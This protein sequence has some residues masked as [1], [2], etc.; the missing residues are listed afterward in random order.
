M[1]VMSSTFESISP[2]FGTIRGRTLLVMEG[3]DYDE[4]CMIYCRFEE[5]LLEPAIFVSSRKILCLI[6]VSF[7]YRNNAVV[8]SIYPS[9][10]P[11]SG[12][13]SVLFVGDNFIGSDNLTCWLSQD[14]SSAFL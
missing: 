6:G 4:T 1:Y 8:S 10:S 7:E 11:I 14:I 3:S 12:G 2:S 13:K 9:S 5:G